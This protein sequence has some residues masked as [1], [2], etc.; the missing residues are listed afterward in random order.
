MNQATTILTCSDHLAAQARH[1]IRQHL[2]HL[3]AVLESHER[4]LPVQLFKRQTAIPRDGDGLLA[5]LIVA[6]AA[7]L[8]LILCAQWQ[9]Q[10]GDDSQD[11][12]LFRDLLH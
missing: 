5:R 9:R 3:A 7:S 4:L 10:A 6:L 11:R 1:A 2:C 8:L 12:C